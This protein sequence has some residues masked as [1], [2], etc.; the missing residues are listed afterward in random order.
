MQIGKFRVLP[1]FQ[2]ELMV[3]KVIKNIWVS[4]TQKSKVGSRFCLDQFLYS[5]K[6]MLSSETMLHK[7]TNEI[8]VIRA[9][10]VGVTRVMEG[11][12][13]CFRKCLAGIA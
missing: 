11:G 6:K 10:I 9:G 1:A 13:D 7:N 5:F 3:M 12:Q 2:I 8:G 4:H